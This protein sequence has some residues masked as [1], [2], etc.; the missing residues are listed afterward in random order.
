VDDSGAIHSLWIP[1]STAHQLYYSVAASGE[2]VSTQTLIDSTYDTCSPR[3]VA[4]NGSGSRKLYYQINAIAGTTPPTGSYVAEGPISGS[5]TTAS[6][7]MDP[8]HSLLQDDGTEWAIL[9]C[10]SNDFAFTFRAPGSSTWSNYYCPAVSGR[11]GIALLPYDTRFLRT[12]DGQVQ[13]KASQGI[14]RVDATTGEAVRAI[15]VPLVDAT[16]DSQ[17]RLHVFYSELDNGVRQLRH[18]Y[19]P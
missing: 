4:I 5:L 11:P 19:Q 10:L 6:T 13:F 2:T 14:Y 1:N 8:M 7:F 12:W 3:A 9:Y 15:T 18:Y 16:Y 17:N